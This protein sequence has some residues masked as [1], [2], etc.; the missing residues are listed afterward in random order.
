MVTHPGLPQNWQVNFRFGVWQLSIWP[1]WL[2]RGSAGKIVEVFANVA[3]RRHPPRE[4][5]D[6]EHRAA[7][8]R[9]ANRDEPNCEVSTRAFPV[10]RPGPP[11]PLAG[12]PH[13]RR[14][15]LHAAEPSRRRRAAPSPA[16]RSQLRSVLD[17]PYRL[18]ERVRERESAPRSPG[19]RT[20][21]AAFRRSGPASQA[22]AWSH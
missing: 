13:C 12:T 16:T 19:P 17:S 20:P 18:D 10:P 5:N 21:V 22:P 9:G 6:H 4:S 2:D 7:D 14:F 8:R 11:G 15:P 3:V 1:A